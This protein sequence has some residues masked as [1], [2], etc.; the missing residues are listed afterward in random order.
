MAADALD[1][2]LFVLT[3]AGQL[4]H[5][6][7]AA[8][9]LLDERRWVRLDAHGR[10]QPTNAAGVVA[11]TAGLQRALEGE[12]VLLDARLFG[13]AGSLAPLGPTH[14]TEPGSL[15]LAL[16]SDRADDVVPVYAAELGLS[17]AQTR[18][19][20]RLVKGASTAETARALG[21]TLATVRSHLASIR[22]KTGHDSVRA[23]L[24]EIASLPPLAPLARTALPLPRAPRVGE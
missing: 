19:L 12:R 9:R 22:E 21:L 1:L 8:R 14:G 6:N 23:L 18:V 10:V 24:Y 3:E 15:L 17:P 16:A 5:A 11:F 4:V 7:A 13:S 20:M 2:R